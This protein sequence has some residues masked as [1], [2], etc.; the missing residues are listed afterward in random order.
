MTGYEYHCFGGLGSVPKGIRTYPPTLGKL[1]IGR[2]Y[3]IFLENNP[4]TCEVGRF[5]SAISAAYALAYINFV[6]G[7][8]NDAN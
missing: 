7:F 2:N 8:S 3:L 5:D 1:G 6:N 4:L